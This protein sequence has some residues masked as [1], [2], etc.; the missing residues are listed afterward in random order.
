MQFQGLV[1]T[2]CYL[3]VSHSQAPQKASNMGCTECVIIEA[4]VKSTVTAGQWALGDSR[5]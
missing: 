2:S 3:S 5:F 1:L 4:P